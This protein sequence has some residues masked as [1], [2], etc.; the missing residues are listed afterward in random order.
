MLHD[1]IRDLY[2]SRCLMR[3]TCTRM[4]RGWRHGHGRRAIKTRRKFRSENCEGKNRRCKWRDIL[5][6]YVGFKSCEGCG[7]TSGVP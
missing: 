6:T 3:I 7:D 2:C 4:R 1:E 5:D